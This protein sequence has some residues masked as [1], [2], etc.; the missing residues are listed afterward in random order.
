MLNISRNNHNFWITSIVSALVLVLILEQRNTRRQLN[1]IQSN[2]YRILNALALFPDKIVNIGQAKFYVPNY[3]ADLI[4]SYIVDRREFFENDILKELQLYIK[5]NAVILDIGGNIGNHCIYWAI[6]SN[7]KRVYSF[8]PIKDTFKILQRNIEINNLSNRIKI[9]NIGLSDR[10]INGNISFYSYTDIGRTS[11]KQ[12][13]NGSL[14][15]NKLDNIKIEED[16]VDFVKIDVEGHELEVLQG[17]RE[18]LLK[19]KPT[20]FI[21][22]F[23]NKKQKVHKYLTN[24]GY[25]L[26]KSFRDHNYLYLFDKKR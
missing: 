15:L 23:P 2:I 9:F 7:A 6:N 24:L 20:I 21:E 22:T 16:A 1:Y 14:L 3:P 11:V 13:P 10:K 18:T 17:A 26:E 19:Y 12:D 25:R 8:E 4:Q 5:N